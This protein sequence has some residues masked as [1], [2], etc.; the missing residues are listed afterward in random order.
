VRLHGVKKDAAPAYHDLLSGFEA[1]TGLG[2]VLNT[3]LNIHGKPIV[4]KPV[5]IADEI[6]I[7]PEVELNNLLIKDRFFAR[8]QAS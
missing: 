3:S 7:Q 8:R 4:H 2:G 1:R 6:L 5:E